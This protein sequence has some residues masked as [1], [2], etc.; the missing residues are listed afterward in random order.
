MCFY[1][2]V[3]T[4]EED[5]SHPV[6]ITRFYTR[7]VQRMRPIH[8]ARI[9]VTKNPRSS[10]SGT[11]LCLGGSSCVKS[12]NGLGSNSQISRF[13]LWRLAQE[14]TC[15]LREARA[16]HCG[17]LSKA[18]VLSSLPDPGD[19]NSSM[20]T[21]PARNAGCIVLTH[22]CMY[23]KM[24]FETLD[25]ILVRVEILRADRRSV[26]GRRASGWAPGTSGGRRRRRL[27]ILM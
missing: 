11:S 24:G 12:K 7:L 26:R 1:I 15:F 2:F 20:H 18:H 23:L 19:L 6:R 13:W 4:S 9:H 3:S 21:I 22:N 27:S 10:D 25:V 5:G 17:R 16:G 14:G 8:V